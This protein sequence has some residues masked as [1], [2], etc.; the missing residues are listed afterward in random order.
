MIAAA[1]AVVAA[2]PAAAA[3]DDTAVVVV[4]DTAI[5][6]VL[7]LAASSQFD[8]HHRQILHSPRVLALLQILMHLASS[9]STTMMTQTKQL[10][11]PLLQGA[12]EESESGKL[13][14]PRRP[15]EP[16]NLRL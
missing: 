7:R 10:V 13:T 11:H 5:A 3:G 12:Y 16:E 8:L 1:A 14:E 6:A 4:V 15:Q 2:A 9:S